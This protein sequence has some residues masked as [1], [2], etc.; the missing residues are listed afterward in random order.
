MHPKQSVMSISFQSFPPRDSFHVS[1][2]L[3]F[4]YLLV[5]IDFQ[6]H[7]FMCSPSS[8][9]FYFFFIHPCIIGTEES[10]AAIWKEVTEGS[11]DITMKQLS[12]QIGRAHV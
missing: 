3:S 9:L 10:A 4:T 1:F 2:I 11:S 8:Q 12:S 5:T 6:F 7:H